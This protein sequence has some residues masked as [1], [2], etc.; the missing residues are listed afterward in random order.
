MPSPFRNSQSAEEAAHKAT[1]CM[2][3]NKNEKRV[4]IPPKWM[5]GVCVRENFLKQVPRALLSCKG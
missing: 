1:Q 2:L 4:A 5:G 3:K